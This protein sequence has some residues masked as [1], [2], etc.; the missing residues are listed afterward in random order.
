[1]VGATTLTLLAGMGA[2]ASF[3]FVVGLAA[4]FIAYGRTYL[5]PLGH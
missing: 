4:T 1:M 3:P 2:A 5:A